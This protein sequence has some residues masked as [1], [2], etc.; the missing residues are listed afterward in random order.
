MAPEPTLL[1]RPRLPVDPAAAGLADPGRRVRG[2]LPGALHAAAGRR[3]RAGRP[4]ATAPG[5]GR[6]V[7]PGGRGAPDAAAARPARRAGRARGGH[8]WPAPP[9]RAA[10]AARCRR[11]HRAAYATMLEAGWR[12]GRRELL[13]GPVPG[14]STARRVWRPR[15][16]A[17]AWR[18]ALLAGGRHV[19]RHILGIRLADRELAAVLVR[20]AALLEVPALLRP[21]RRLLRG[22]R[23]RRPGPGP[24][25]L[26]QRRAGP[27]APALTARAGAAD[28]D[29]RPQLTGGRPAGRR[30]CARGAVH[31]AQCSRVSRSWSARGRRAPPPPAGAADAAGR[32][33]PG[34]PAA[35]TSR[36]SR[37]GS[38]SPP[39]ARPP[40]TTPSASRWPPSSTGSCPGYGPAWWSPPPRREN[41]RLVGSGAA[42]LGFTQADVLPPRR[43]EH[44]RRARG[45]PGL[46]RPAAPGHHRRRPGPRRSP[47]CAAGGSRWARAG[48]GTEV[49]ATRLLEV[50]RLG[51]D[52][53]R[54][55]HLGLDDSVAALRAGRIDAFFFSGGLPVRGV[56]ELAGAHR[57]PDRRP[58]RVDRAAAPRATGRSTCPGTSPARCTGWTRS[59]RWRTRTT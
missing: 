55:E 5:R 44:P 27:A 24:R 2:R 20:G 43:P 1:D 21:G 29:R 54:Q 59:P 50:A 25:I 23:R 57:H 58:G 35:G 14:A 7:Q 41:V 39:A 13:G 9:L 18:S 8:R 52:R 53:V 31:G 3:R 32:R 49:T 15:L 34:S 33:W 47:T 38:G 45:G 30:A 48:S 12:Q 19:R 40:S 51:G 28:G 17:A 42:E 11:E 46:R 36:P 16:A 26:R 56:A 4:P 6:R 37:S 22:E 10:P